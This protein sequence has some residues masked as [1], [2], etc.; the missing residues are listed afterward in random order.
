MVEDEV[1]RAYCIVCL[2]EMG[3]ACKMSENL[4]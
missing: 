4:D 2:T 1:G 3:S